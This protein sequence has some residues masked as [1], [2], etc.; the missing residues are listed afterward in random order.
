MIGVIANPADHDVTRELFELFKTRRPPI[1]GDSVTFGTTEG[2]ALT[3]EWA[4]PAAC[5]T[6]C[7]DSVVVRHIDVGKNGSLEH[8]A[9]LLPRI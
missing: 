1:Y 3:D 6:R 9:A 8:E 7:G 4:R 5:V 2:V